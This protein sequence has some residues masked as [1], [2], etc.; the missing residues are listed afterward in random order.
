MP[1]AQVVG[2]I[3]GGTILTNIMQCLAAGG[4]V[5]WSLFPCCFGIFGIVFLVVWIWALVDAVSNEPSEGNDKL[6]WILIIVLAGIIGAIIYL[7]VRR[8][9]RIRRFGK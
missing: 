9:E 5:L 8:P 3:V 1:L 2:F 6:I 4:P 7:A